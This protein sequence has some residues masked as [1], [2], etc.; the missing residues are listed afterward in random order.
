MPR[1]SEA[2]MLVIINESIN[3]DTHFNNGEL[4]SEAGGMWSQEYVFDDGS[5]ADIR[6]N[7]LLFIENLVA[8]NKIIKSQVNKFMHLIWNKLVEL[9]KIT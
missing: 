8:E 9:K 2:H 5:R 4:F 7:Q 3:E 1:I 6:P